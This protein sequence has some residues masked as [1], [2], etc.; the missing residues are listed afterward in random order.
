MF[1]HPNHLLSWSFTIIILY[2]P[3]RL[4]IDI[5]YHR[6]LSSSNS[7]SS[8]SSLPSSSPSPSSSSSSSSSSITSSKICWTYALRRE[9]EP[10]TFPTAFSGE[11]RRR[12]TRKILRKDLSN[13]PKIPGKLS[14]AGTNKN[15]RNFLQNG[16]GILYC[17][18]QEFSKFK[19]NGFF[20]N[21]RNPGNSARLGESQRWVS[22]FALGAHG[23]AIVGPICAFEFP[24]SL[25]CNMFFCLQIGM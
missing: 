23:Y 25:L 1:Y 20:Q 4:N 17:A 2:H 6:P 14:K 13:V 22:Y 8:L 10:R 15:A 19:Q 18:A 9:S 21:F 7:S 12:T 3:Y 16:A 11:P 24:R 5:L